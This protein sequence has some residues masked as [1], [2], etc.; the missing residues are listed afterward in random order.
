MKRI[1]FS[2]KP[3][4]FVD[5]KQFSEADNPRRVAIQT[6]NKLKTVTEID[7]LF[8]STFPQLESIHRCEINSNFWGLYILTFKD[9]VSAK[10][11]V[12]T[13]QFEDSEFVKN[14]MLSTLSDYLSLREKFLTQKS[15]PK[16][17]KSEPVDNWTVDFQNLEKVH[18]E[19]WGDIETEYRHIY[20]KIEQVNTLL[21]PSRK[22]TEENFDLKSPDVFVGCEGFGDITER[23]K[24]DI[25]EY[26]YENHENVVTVLFSTLVFAK[27]SD[28]IS[29]ER[30]FT[31]N[32]IRFRGRKITPFKLDNFVLDLNSKDKMDLIKLLSGRN[33]TPD[34]DDTSSQDSRSPADEIDTMHGNSISKIVLSGFHRENHH[35]KMLMRANLGDHFGSVSWNCDTSEEYEATVE[36]VT[37]LNEARRLVDKWNEMKTPID[38]MII[39]ARLV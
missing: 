23:S 15:A 14:P 12:K 1:R 3:K 22:S 37:G 18:Q 9:E 26:F 24:Q 2:Q 32:Y 5:D 16:K 11:A 38:K 20:G 6:V 33:L 10:A 29:A 17:N 7:I 21:S 25:E 19:H 34:S 30:F 28:Q 13:T 8:E 4:N 31:L 35:L 36:V 27:F 39:T